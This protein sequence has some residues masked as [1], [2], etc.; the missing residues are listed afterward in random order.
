[1]CMFGVTLEGPTD[2][3]C[4]NTAVFKNTSTPEYVLRKKHH[5]IAYNKCREG[6][7]ALICRIAKE[8]T[9]TNLADLFTKIL[10]RT[11]REWLMNLFHC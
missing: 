5:S 7:A 6:V 8:D 3:F 1:M 9:Q 2:M 10:G 11:R 4:D